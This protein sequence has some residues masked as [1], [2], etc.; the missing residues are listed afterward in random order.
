MGKGPIPGWGEPEKSAD[1]G[2]REYQPEPTRAGAAPGASTRAG[3]APDRAATGAAAGEATGDAKTGGGKSAAPAAD[4]DGTEDLLDHMLGEFRI[5]RRLGRGGMAEV[6]LAEQTQLKRNVAVK[7]LHKDRVT[8]A[9][10]LK[11]FKTE[12]MAAGSLSHPNIVQVHSIG[13]QDGI[14]YIAQEYVPGMNLREFLARKGPPELALAVRIIRQ[15]AAALQ[16]A[17]AA[18]I[19]HRDIKPENIMLTRKGEVKVADFG[20]AQLTQ[21]GERVNLTQDGVTMGLRST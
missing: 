16:A 17:H 4:P 14:H 15:A 1:E 6:Y 18:G 13:E 21:A 5:L 7:V 8:D 3:G 12:A 9:N 19:V 2:P 11:R 20:L 10:Y